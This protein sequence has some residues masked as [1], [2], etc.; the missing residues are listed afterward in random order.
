[1]PHLSM[2]QS[3]CRKFLTCCL[4]MAIIWEEMRCVSVTQHSKQFH[5]YGFEHIATVWFSPSTFFSPGFVQWF[6]WSQNYIADLYWPYLLPAVKAYG[7]WQNS[8][9]CKRA[10]SDP[11]QATYGRSISVRNRSI[12]AYFPEC[13]FLV[14][15]HLK[16][17]WG[18]YANDGTEMLEIKWIQSL[19][20]GVLNVRC[21]T[22]W[23]F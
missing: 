15:S 18:Y 14:F 17:H 22:F 9:P 8:F 10:N 20:W 5:C 1:M 7:R 2:M 6:H 13:V 21:N 16:L 4:T 19:R 11:E 23:K 12:L 3:M